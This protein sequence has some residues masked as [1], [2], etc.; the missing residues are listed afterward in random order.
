MFIWGGGCS[1]T[2]SRLAG[3]LTLGAGA[4]LAVVAAVNVLSLAAHAPMI[5]F[6]CVGL[7]YYFFFLSASR[8]IPTHS[9]VGRGN[10]VLRHSVFYFLPNSGGIAC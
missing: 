1:L 10:L 3:G 7:L 5:W 8:Y 2:V 6:F 9:R 4:C